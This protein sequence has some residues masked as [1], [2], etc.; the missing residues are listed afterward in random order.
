MSDAAEVSPYLTAN[1]GPVRDELT[2]TELEVEG[3]I[4]PELSGRYLRNGPNP[5][6]I[7]DGYYHWFLGDGMIHGIELGAGRAS[8]YRNR[9]VRTDSFNSRHDAEPAPGPPDVFPLGNP[10][11]TNVVGHA[12]RIFALCEVGLPYEL[13]RDL[14]TIGRTDFGGKLGSP[15]TAHP[16]I[17]PV[18]GEMHFFGYSFTPPFCRYHVL[19]A[20]GELIKSEVIELPASVMMHDFAITSTRVIFMDLPVVFDMELA[21]R[22]QFPFRWDVDNGARLG[23]MPRTGSGGDVNWIAIDPC[24]VFHP[25][26]AY[27]DG[28]RVVMDVCRFDSMFEQRDESGV[29]GPLDSDLPTLTRWEIDTRA[30]VLKESTLDD[31]AMEFPRIDE[32]RVGYEYRYGYSL[33]LLSSEVGTEFGHIFKRD[34]RAGTIEVHNLGPGRSAGEAVFVPASDIAGEDEGWVMSIVYDSR[35]DKSDLVIVD[36]TDFE[37]SPTAVIHLPTRVPYGFHG[38]W[39][40]DS[41]R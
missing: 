34:H 35:S 13:T 8:W 1:Y 38:N 16:K 29:D 6:P 31:R 21:G 39:I 22:G 27:D 3:A 20:S 17:D 10:A 40:P 24:Y 37:G 19:D 36:A 41:G 33:E 28:D 4:P 23:V 7:P 9:W 14:S 11:N 32:R 5:D 30:G 15:M 25:M 12:G 26:N 2:V 18:T